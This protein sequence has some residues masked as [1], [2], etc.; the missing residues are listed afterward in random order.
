[1]K[2]AAAKRVRNCIDTQ[3]IYNT[4]YVVS[5][6]NTIHVYIYATDVVWYFQWRETHGTS[7]IK[8]EVTHQRTT[9]FLPNDQRKSRKSWPT[10]F[11]VMFFAITRIVRDSHWTSG[12]R[13]F[14]NAWNRKN[15]GGYFSLDR[16]WPHVTPFRHVLSA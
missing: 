9:D 7:A 13:A 15:D 1:M 10:A 2:L 8:R 12:T 14:C 6:D 11:F 16:A 5:N 4:I 3:T